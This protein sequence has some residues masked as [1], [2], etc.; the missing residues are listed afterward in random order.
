MGAI[1]GISDVSAPAVTR[2]PVVKQVG[3]AILMDGLQRLEYRGYDSAGIVVLR[4][5]FCSKKTVGK[6]KEQ[7]APEG[8]GFQEGS[9]DRMVIRAGR[10]RAHPLG[11]PRRRLPVMPIRSFLRYPS[12]GHNG[13]RE[14]P[15]LRQNLSQELRLPV[16]D[17]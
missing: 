14:L 4:M 3:S 9:P 13:A 16:R 12:R 11:N 6:V 17:R 7:R 10:H 2:T 8:T 5:E 15:E 1:C